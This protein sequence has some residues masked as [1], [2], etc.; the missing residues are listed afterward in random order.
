MKIP[1]DWGSDHSI[2]LMGLLS[3][4]LH[5]RRFKAKVHIHM[6]R[7]DT[8]DAS[9]HMRFLETTLNTRRNIGDTAV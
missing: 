4:T 1:G 7:H 8:R 3:I 9:N 5:K 2:S 6:L